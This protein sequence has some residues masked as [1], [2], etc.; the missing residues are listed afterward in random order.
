MTLTVIASMQFGRSMRGCLPFA[1]KLRTELKSIKPGLLLLAED[2]GSLKDV[3]KAG[4]DAAYDWT[5]DTAWVSH[6]SWQYQYAPRKNLTLFNHPDAGKRPAMLK[7]ALF[8]NGDATNLR[9]R[10]IENNDLPRFIRSHS[11]ICTKM[12]AALL[13]SLP[14]IPMHL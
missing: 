12:A 1:K 2:K 8:N 5:A 13:F 14:G 4:F 6:W 3:Y 9:L 10:F 11:L 7:K